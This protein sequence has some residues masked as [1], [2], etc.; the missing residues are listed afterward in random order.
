MAPIKQF[1]STVNTRPWLYLS[2]ST[3]CGIASILLFE[4]MDSIRL[5]TGS[6]II[7][8]NGQ[9]NLIGI[10]PCLLSRIDDGDVT[11]TQEEATMNIIAV[12]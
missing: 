6:Y 7:K 12:K 4:Y 10:Q 9:W 2:L 1:N 3:R 5:P 8:G 11:Y